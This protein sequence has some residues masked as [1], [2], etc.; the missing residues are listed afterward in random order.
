MH[1]KVNNTSYGG[2]GPKPEGKTPFGRNRC[3]WEKNIILDLK[4][5]GWEDGDWINLAMDRVRWQAL[6]KQLRTFRLHK[7]QEFS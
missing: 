7:T 1:S 5:T 2:G 4:E 3:R 6:C